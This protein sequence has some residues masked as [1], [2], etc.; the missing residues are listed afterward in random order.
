MWRATDRGATL[1]I[2]DAAARGF[3]RGAD[4]YAVARPGYPQAV[5]DTLA[6]EVGIGAGTT[7]CDLAAGTGKFTS[8]L[9]AL[10]ATVV[11]V[12]PVAAMRAHLVEDLPT[13]RA[14]DGTAEAI[15]LDDGSVDAIT[16]AQAFHWFDTVPALAEIHRVLRPGGA[17]VLVWNVRDESVDWVH[18]F[19]ELIVERSGGRPYTPYHRSDGDSRQMD[20]RLAVVTEHGFGPLTHATFPNVQSASPEVVVA[21]AASTSFVSALPDDERSALL[22][23]VRDLI[24][25]HP[26]TAG[27]PHFPFPHRTDL[28]WCRAT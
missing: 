3:D 21:R 18:R 27:R 16:I 17:L 25:T 22:R 10:G 11:A 1:S 4:D 23:A 12:E 19:T 24:D 8:G 20:E 2:E 13:V 7:V 5:F 14:A 15:P 9:V 28:T 6:R 26:D